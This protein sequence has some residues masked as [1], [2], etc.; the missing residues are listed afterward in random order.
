MLTHL[1]VQI[2]KDATNNIFSHCC[3]S[4]SVFKYFFSLLFLMSDIS[5]LFITD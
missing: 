2:L 4:I 3:A 1:M 5:F